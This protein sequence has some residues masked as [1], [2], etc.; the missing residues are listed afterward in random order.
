[1]NFQP[2]PSA[3]IFFKSASLSTRGAE[4]S[5]RLQRPDIVFG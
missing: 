3:L 2:P 5:I 1:V 4:A